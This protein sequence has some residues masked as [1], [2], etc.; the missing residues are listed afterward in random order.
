MDRHTATVLDFPRIQTLLAE[1]ARSPQGAELCRGLEPLPTLE[2]T[3]RALD[4]L[5]A[6]IALEPILGPPP[7]GGLQ[8]VEESLEAARKEGACLEREAVLE[9]RD[10]VVVCH[11]VLDY[12]EDAAAEGSD[13]GAYAGRIQPLYGLADRFARTF[14]PRGEILDGASA[15]LQCLRDDLKRLRV[16]ILKVLET[17]LRDSQVEP[18]VQDEF[19]TVRGD[20]YVIPLR[21]DFRGYLEG[22]VH[23]RSRSGATFFVEPMEVVEL[24]NQLGLVREEE[25]AEIRNILLELTAWLGRE[26]STLRANIAVVAHLD[27]LGARLVLA[28]KLGAERPQLIAEPLVD[29]RGARHPLLQSQLGGDVVP[30]DLH[31]GQDSRLLLI[32]G[33]NSG[34]KTVSLK[35]AGLLVLMARSGLFIPAAEGS[36]VGWFDTL[37][38]DIGDEQNIDRQL[39]TFTAHATHLR[40]IL[41]RAGKGSLVLLDELG[42]GTDPQEGVGLAMAVLETLL[43]QG[44]IVIGTTHLAGLK[45]FAYA[46]PD[47]QNAAVAFDPDTGRP[48]YRLIYGRAGTSNALKVAEQ[49]GMPRNVLTKAR[50]Y[51]AGGDEPV[52]RVLSE[53]EDAKDAAIR[54]AEE[55]ETLRQELEALVAKQQVLVAE[56]RQERDAARADARRE[57]LAVIAEARNGLRQT[58]RAFAR[59]RASQQEAEEDIRRAELT[60]D[61]ALRRETPTAKTP[62]PENL[63]PGARVGVTSLRRDGVVEAFDDNGRKVVVRVGTLRVTVPVQDL[64]RAERAG[65]NSP[66]ASPVRVEAERVAPD[67]VVVGCTVDEALARVDKALD[68]ALL[69]GVEGFRVVHGRGTGTLRRAVREHLVEVPQVR[70]VRPVGNDVATWVEVG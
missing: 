14:G 57:A 22:I 20:R 55:S 15:A 17:V 54:A 21:T 48:L 5:E 26:A 40:D 45:A 50:A 44:A 32:T 4:E 67:V 60:V 42:T 51:A 59:R 38:A 47:G 10:T 7:T 31:L 28:R 56:A 25:Q 53:L 52:S 46:R 66:R 68:R 43:D 3:H 37:G 61:Q 23:D 36:R 19:V 13:L 64:G 24:N 58:I 2:A 6:L 35:T 63:S 9:L 65:V 70:G 30:V 49:L 41:Q 29:L 18:A 8:R 33:A 16:R 27:A 12:L 1:G 34:G 62:P 69:A 39:S 11:R